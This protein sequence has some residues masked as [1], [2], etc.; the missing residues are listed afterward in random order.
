MNQKTQIKLI[1]AIVGIITVFFPWYS[2]RIILSISR[3][4]IQ[5]VWGI[6]AF[7]G[8]GGTIASLFVQEIK[9]YTHFIAIAP[10]AASLIG[11]IAGA[12][13]MGFGLILSLLVSGGLVAYCWMN[14]EE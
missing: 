12:R 8:F 10:A 1:I 4:G 11:L 14:K 2:V 13:I 7:L 9:K 3:M 5:T 6:L